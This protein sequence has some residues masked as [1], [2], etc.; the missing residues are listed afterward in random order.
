MKLEIVETIA[1]TVARIAREFDADV[2]LV[3]TETG[4]TYHFI[5]EL[6]S[7]EK[8]RVIAATSSPRTFEHLKSQHS[9]VVMVTRIASRI[10]QIERAISR[11]LKEGLVSS[12]ELLVCL[13]GAE[14]GADADTIFIHRVTDPELKVFTLAEPNP[15]VEAALEI[16]IQLG[17]EG[18][19]GM[20]V[21]AAF[22][23]G[24]EGRVMELSS[25]IGINP[26][27][28]YS[29]SLLDR[30]NWELVKKYT[31]AF[32][33]ALVVGRDG[34]IIAGDRYLRAEEV[35]VD[36][37]CGLGTRHR[38]VARITAATK[39]VGIVVSEGDRRIRIF[40]GGQLVGT[41]NP[42]NE[43]WLEGWGACQHVSEAKRSISVVA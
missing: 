5:G 25:Q 38:A 16:A 31:L 41:F 21:G 20:S 35:E 12:G 6:I 27:K 13:I 14:P 19:N 39:A 8:P 7:S 30:R 43:M 37:P 4:R 23:I 26:F 11:G 9:S 10:G 3:F 28:G 33:G 29:L 36:V 17:R 2:I 40:Q 22:I 15:A 24:D 1:A 42:L 18:M 32:E 34:T